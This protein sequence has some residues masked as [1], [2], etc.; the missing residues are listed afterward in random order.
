MHCSV[1][2]MA[3]F[4]SSQRSAVLE[5]RERISRLQ[6]NIKKNDEGVGRRKKYNENTRE[7]CYDFPK[8]E[9]GNDSLQG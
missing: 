2:F 9:G 3:S 5:N 8:T 6:Q 7:M 1:N 4:F